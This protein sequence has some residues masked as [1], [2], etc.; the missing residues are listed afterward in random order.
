MG[1]LMFT[2]VIPLDTYILED[3][4]GKPTSKVLGCVARKRKILFFFKKKKTFE[5]N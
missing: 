4:N 1:Q 5:T 3:I 2:R